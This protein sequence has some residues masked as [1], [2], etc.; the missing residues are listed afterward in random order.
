MSY[1]TELMR[2]VRHCD[3]STNG[4]WLEGIFVSATKDEPAHLHYREK[5]YTEKVEYS[6]LYEEDIERA[7]KAIYGGEAGFS[8][9]WVNK[10]RDSH[11]TGKVTDEVADS[12]VQVA[13]FGELTYWRFPLDGV[14]PNL[15]MWTYEPED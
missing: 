12:V 10:V 13:I 3:L 9:E 7:I 2:H 6:H 15:F 14:I 11:N 8:E 1:E 4:S 5:G